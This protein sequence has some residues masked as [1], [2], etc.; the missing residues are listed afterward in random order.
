MND[1]RAAKPEITVGY[2]RAATG[3]P[4]DSRRSIERQ[5]GLCLALA[6]EL[7][8]NLSRAYIDY[9]ASGMSADRPGLTG[10][11]HDLSRGGADFVITADLARLAR[12]E[13]LSR[14]LQN[15]IDRAGATLLTA[16]T[17]QPA[18]KP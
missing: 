13:R 5:P 2:L 4:A 12:D 7:N 10:M 15:Q 17:P 6:R 9:G 3:N 11:M 16:T 18:G 1:T 14:S 8:L